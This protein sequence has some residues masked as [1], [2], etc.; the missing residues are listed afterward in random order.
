MSQDFT[1]VG[2]DRTEQGKGA[3]RRLRREGKVPGILYGGRRPP[4]TLLL[5]RDSLT[6]SLSN[7]A[8]YSSILTLTVGDKSQPCIIKDVQRHPARNVIMH[9]DLQRILAD[10]K[11]RVSVPV[12]LV[13]EDAAPGVKLGGQ[14]SHI[15]TELEVTCLPK[16]L[17]EYIEAD[18]SGLEM[19][20][21]LHISELKI[22]DGVEILAGEGAMDQPVATVHIIRVQAEEEE[23]GAEGEGEVP[24]GEVPTTGDE[25]PEDDKE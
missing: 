3:S 22:P 2:E 25:E 11:I 10:E 8:V 14:V 23:E 6:H 7:E 21:I 24:A 1:L 5:D 20:G 12:N 18:V 19:D 4:R 15:T 17:P 16:D 13:G 9:I